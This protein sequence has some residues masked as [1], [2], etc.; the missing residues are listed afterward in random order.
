[1]KNEIKLKPVFLADSLTE[2]SPFADVQKAVGQLKSCIQGWH[3]QD[4]EDIEYDEYVCKDWDY[5]HYA[6]IMK[7]GS[8][9]IANAFQDEDS[10]AGM[11]MYYLRF[12]DTGEYVDT[13]LIK[14]WCRLPSDDPAFI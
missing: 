7:D 12:Q 8:W 11:V 5:V 13:N 9:R 3:Y 4:K 14:M 6:L 2:Q 1:M 10:E